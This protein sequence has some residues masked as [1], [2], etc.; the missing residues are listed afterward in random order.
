MRLVCSFQ[1]SCVKKVAYVCGE[2]AADDAV[3][4]LGRG[5][6]D[7]VDG[8]IPNLD[9]SV[10]EEDSTEGEKQESSSSIALSEGD[11][12]KSGDVAAAA[13]KEEE[14][15]EEFKQKDGDSA[16]TTSS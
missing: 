12:I 8:I 11:N 6:G 15:E 16:T 5:G 4:R 2:G 10:V 13:P 7:V 1:E 3:V 9:L 14:E